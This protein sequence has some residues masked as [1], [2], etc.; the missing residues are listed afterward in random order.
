MYI[1]AVIVAILSASISFVA[2]DKDLSNKTRLLRPKEPDEAEDKDIKKTV[3]LII[4]V[5][6][7]FVTLG[8][9]LYMA[10]TE[11]D[12]L[13]FMKMSV[14]T[15]CLSGAASNDYRDHRISNIFPLIMAVCAIVFLGIGYF[16]SQNGATAYIFSSIFAAVVVA[17]FMILASILTR[18][19]VGMG[20]I[21]LLTALALLGGVNTIGWTLIFGVGLCAIVAVILLITKKK[22]IKGTLPFGPFIFIGYILTILLNKY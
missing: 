9:S 15:I 5:C 11:I 6:V 16:S 8:A 14:G 4:S 22:S 10:S 21:K 2:L 17:I 1:L 3:R 18:R 7:L 19:G 20:D 12:W 13:G